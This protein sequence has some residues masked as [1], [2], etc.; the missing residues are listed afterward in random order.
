MARKYLKD[1]KRK[2]EVFKGILKVD[3]GT[4]ESVVIQLPIKVLRERR[5]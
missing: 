5:K 4:K 3:I 2:S 1:I